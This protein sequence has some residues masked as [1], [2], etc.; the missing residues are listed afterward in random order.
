MAGLATKTAAAVQETSVRPVGMPTF[1]DDD[2]IR[3]HVAE[4]AYFLAE[5]RGFEPG[6]E[7]EDWL[8]AERQVHDEFIQTA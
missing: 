7:L 5:H 4:A 8:E 1:V 3:Q 6:H 2:V